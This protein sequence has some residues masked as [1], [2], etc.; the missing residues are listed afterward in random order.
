MQIAG[1]S[2]NTTQAIEPTTAVQNNQ[3]EGRQ[4]DALQQSETQNTVTS[5][6][7]TSL[8]NAAVVSQTTESEQ[9]PFDSE[10]RGNNVDITV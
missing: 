9:T 8:S 6:E 10:N 3:L 7:S 4:T 2:P 1:Y 5:S